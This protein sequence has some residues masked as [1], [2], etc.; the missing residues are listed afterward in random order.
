VIHDCDVDD[1]ARGVLDQRGYG[2]FFVHRTGQSIGAEVHGNGVN[3][4]NFE[5]RDERRILPGL[6]FSME[7]GVY[8]PEFGIRSEINLFS[9]EDTA[10]VTGD[11]QEDLLLPV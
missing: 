2:R 11:I 6:C 8:L 5:T 7:P 1:A 3:I 10:E 9:G 4:D